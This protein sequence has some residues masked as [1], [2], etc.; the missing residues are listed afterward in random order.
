MRAIAGFAG[1]VAVVYAAIGA[2]AA[3]AAPAKPDLARG[4]QIATTVC[5]ACHGASGV[6]P[7]PANPHIAGQS[8]DYIAAQLEAFKSGSRANPIMAGMAAGLSPEDMRNVG[9]YYQTQK[10]VAGVARDKALALKGKLVWQAGVKQTGVPA[11]AG[12]HGA[13]GRGMPVQFPALAGQY[14]EVTYGW[15][16]AYATGGRTNSVMGAVAAKMSDAEMKA[17]SEFISGL[18]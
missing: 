6:S 16:K 15:L 11:C 2:A 3:P 7:A 5:A 18:R 9:A 12:C 10:P 13:N 1:V 4:Q 14:S 8:G 17:V